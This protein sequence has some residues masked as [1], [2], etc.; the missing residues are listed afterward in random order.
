MHFYL[1]LPYTLCI[2]CLYPLL[3]SLQLT[4]H[5][6]MKSTHLVLALQLCIFR[7]PPSASENG[8]RKRPAATAEK[9]IRATSDKCK[10]NTG[11]MELNRWNSGI[12][13]CKWNAP[14]PPS[15]LNCSA[16]RHATFE[17]AAIATTIAIPSYFHC[18]RL[19]STFTSQKWYPR[20]STPNT[21]DNNT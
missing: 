9:N 1:L 2:L 6:L 11:E 4:L 12:R 16:N 5:A 20:V 13:V 8:N 15:G 21:F 7:L 10:L 3:C 14:L 19:N 18:F 17:T